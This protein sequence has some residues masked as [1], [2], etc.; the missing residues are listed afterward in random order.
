MR[1]TSMLP[2]FSQSFQF[3]RRKKRKYLFHT[4]TVVSVRLASVIALRIAMTLQWYS[5]ILYDNKCVP[6]ANEH[7]FTCKLIRA[8]YSSTTLVA[9]LL[10]GE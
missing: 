4:F 9:A 6:A 2:C 5:N 3:D 8:N 10:G 7:H 1:N